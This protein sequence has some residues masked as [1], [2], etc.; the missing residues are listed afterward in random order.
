MIR[1]S[2]A[3]PYALVLPAGIVMGAV[4]LFPLLYNFYLAFR[5]MSLYRF[6]NH[7]FESIA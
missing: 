7:Q 3:F 6:A 4:V 2:R 1:A 5:N